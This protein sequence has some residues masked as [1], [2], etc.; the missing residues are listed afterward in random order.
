[1]RR[2]AAVPAVVL[3]VAAAVAGAS[4]AALEWTRNAGLDFWNLSAERAQLHATREREQDLDARY[5]A[6]R[7]RQE[8]AEGIAAAL[9]DGTITLAEA[10]E[11][12]R[13]LATADP[14][15]F[16]Q[17]AFGYRRAGHVGPNATER[18]ITI[19]YLLI[20]IESMRWAAEQQGD[21]SRAA[22]LSTRLAQLEEELRP[23]STTPS[24]IPP[25]H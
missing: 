4:Q 10:I 15:L 11:R 16:A 21:P 2:F 9:C 23:A 3:G 24:V 19:R 17:R 12:A 20:K 25:T 13:A 14:E 5:E 7:R 6:G 8:A 22:C 18:D 1:M